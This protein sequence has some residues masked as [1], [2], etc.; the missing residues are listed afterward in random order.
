[1]GNKIGIEIAF[2]S[3]RRPFQH[4]VVRPVARILPFDFLF[5]M[6]LGR[7]DDMTS[8]HQLETL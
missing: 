8:Q 7:G 2:H 3:V 6:G 4:R 1:M 5:S